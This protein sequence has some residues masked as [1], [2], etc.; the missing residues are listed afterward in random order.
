MQLYVVSP[1]FGV[2]TVVVC[3]GVA[4]LAEKNKVTA[5]FHPRLQSLSSFSLVL[6]ESQ[7]SEADGI[8]SPSRQVRKGYSENMTVKR[9]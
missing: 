5:R 2:L 1:V 3:Y 9:S 7:P 8:S 4:K 6:K